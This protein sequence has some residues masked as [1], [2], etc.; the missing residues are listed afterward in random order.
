MTSTYR[1][2]CHDVITGQTI[3][4]NLPLTVSSLSRQ[5]NSIGTLDGSLNLLAAN[6]ALTR[7]W[8]SAIEARRAMLIAFQDEYPVWAGV[9]TSW[10][11]Q[12]VLDGTLPI[13]AS[14]LEWL[15]QYRVISDPLSYVS[16]DVLTIFSS[17][18]QYAVSKGPNAAIAGL[19]IPSAL[20]GI[21]ATINFDTSSLTKVYDAISTL[22]TTYG[23]EYSIRPGP[24]PPTGD[25]LHYADVGYPRLGGATGQVFQMPGNLL[26]YMY[27]RNGDQF[28]NTIYGTANSGSQ[29]L[30]TIQTNDADL[31]AGYPLM[32]DS[33]SWSA[34]V[35]QSDLD[36]FAAGE[37][38]R[39]AQSERQPLL[40][41]GTG[42]HPLVSEVNLGDTVVFLGT[43]PLH[44]ATDQGQPGLQ[45]A[46]RVTGWTLYP[47]GPNQV[48][49]TQYQL[50][51]MVNLSP[52]PF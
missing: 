23:F 43:D 16:T 37:L 4:D 40:T 27:A 5:I 3:G 6:P 34:S 15:L 36:A 7:S 45:T 13:T 50:M 9:V 48:E 22:I 32:E 35:Y 44:P 47:P 46:A 28:A 2:H 17:L 42:Q 33:V 30:T 39:R 21:F 24:L 31:A 26:D 51:Q 25:L 49:Q 41:L 52:N 14:T 18:L 1:Y 38:V 8:V 11:H 20:S 29:T 19:Q 10:P 12:S